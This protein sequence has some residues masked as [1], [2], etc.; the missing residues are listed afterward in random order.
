M[1]DV[2]IED[3]FLNL[4]SEYRLKLFSFYQFRSLFA[5]LIEG[6]ILLDRLVYLM[7]QVCRRISRNEF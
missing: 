6:I 3:V 7:E 1:T 5:S 4:S 2:E